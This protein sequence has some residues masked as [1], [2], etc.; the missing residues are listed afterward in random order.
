M[1]FVVLCTPVSL[2]NKVMIGEK[3]SVQGLYKKP[4]YLEES[5]LLTKLPDNLV[6]LAI[7]VLF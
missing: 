3:I 5:L 6:F 4:K 1:I 7:K 2:Y